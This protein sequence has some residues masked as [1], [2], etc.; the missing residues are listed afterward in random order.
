MSSPKGLEQ[1]KDVKARSPRLFSSLITGLQGEAESLSEE[2]VVGTHAMH[3]TGHC[4]SS[5]ASHITS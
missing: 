4:D 2:R 1:N 3:N 5:P